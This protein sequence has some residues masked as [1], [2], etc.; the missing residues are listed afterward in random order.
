[1]R[2]LLI[3][4][5]LGVCPVFGM[6]VE[7]RFN[8]GYYD[9]PSK[10][11]TQVNINGS[12][13]CSAKKKDCLIIN[14]KKSGVFFVEI[15]SN[16]S[17]GHTCSMYGDARQEGREL[18]Y[19]SVHNGEISIIDKGNYFLIRQNAPVDAPTP[20]CGAG[21]SLDGLTFKKTN[22]KIK[23]ASCAQR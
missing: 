11:C 8:E 15:F 13:K 21:A 18:K 20:F 7:Q 19:E 4:F 9:E 22:R 1:M 6:A 2:N 16:Q 5:A 12:R 3:I 23:D 10:F 14:S 17:A